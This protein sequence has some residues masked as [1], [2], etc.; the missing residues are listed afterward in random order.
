MQRCQ[1]KAI[2]L[3][4]VSLTLFS[5]TL[6]AQQTDLK[7]ITTRDEALVQFLGGGTPLAPPEQAEIEAAVRQS[8]AT[9]PQAAKAAASESEQLTILMKGRTAIEM[10]VLLQL[11]RRAIAFSS[12]QALS[13]QPLTAT[14]VRIVNAHDPVV[15]SD[16]AKQ[17]LVTRQTVR[18]LVEANRKAARI[19]SV[20]EPPPGPAAVD[21]LA[22]SIHANWPTI[23]DGFRESLSNAQRDLPFAE[24]YLAESPPAAIAKFISTYHDKIM[25]GRDAVAHQ[26][27]LAEV[28]SFVGKFGYQHRGSLPGNGM[29]AVTRA[30]NDQSMYDR[31]GRSLMPG[32]GVAAGSVM[33]PER[34]QFCNP[35]PLP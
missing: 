18:A 11:G 3:A 22:A 9:D 10:A 19:F 14:A 24:P 26:F 12:L 13:P 25:A 35:S 30:R 23:D 21:T 16:P 15:A 8:F 5:S 17:Y 27:N 33:S 32:C 31:A 4:S 29:D 28:I 7:A 2:F 6:N 34:R 1:A 20:P